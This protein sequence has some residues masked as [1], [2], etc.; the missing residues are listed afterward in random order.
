MR[1]ILLS[2]VLLGSL[3]SP[4][5]VQDQ[6]HAIDVIS[7]VCDENANVSD[8]PS[9]CED[10]DASIASNS[11]PVFGPDSLLARAV[12]ILSLVGGVIAVIVIIIGGTKLIVS[13]GDSN[14]IASARRTIL[15]AAISLLI[16]ASAQLLVR[17]ILSKLNL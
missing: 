17:L 13:G 7:P 6:S 15:F 2:L 11:N 8:V 16:I 5:V 12:D 14:G 4:V 3:L 10:N 9:V 1:R